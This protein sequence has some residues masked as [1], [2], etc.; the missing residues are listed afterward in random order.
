MIDEKPYENIL[1]CYISYKT[2]N[3]V[4]SLY[5]IIN[6]VNGYIKKSD[7]NKYLTL[8]PL[9]FIIHNSG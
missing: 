6:K 8:F 9:D 1:T 2:K 4:K 7:G 5:L 3:S